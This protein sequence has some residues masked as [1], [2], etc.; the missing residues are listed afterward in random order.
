M[1]RVLACLKQFQKAERYSTM[2][3]EGF[4]RQFIQKYG[5][6]GAYS[7]DVTENRV[8]S[9]T[10]GMTPE[11]EAL[12]R[13]LSISFYTNASHKEKIGQFQN[14]LEAALEA[15][16]YQQKLIDI[17]TSRD[18]SL[19]T[20]IDLKIDIL[21][22]KLNSKKTFKEN[23]RLIEQRA[24]ENASKMRGSLSRPGSANIYSTQPLEKQTGPKIKKQ[25]TT[26]RI[27]PLSQTKTTNNQFNPKIIKT[28]KEKIVGSQPG[29]LKEIV[30]DPAT[31]K[32][33]DS[34]GMRVTSL[35]LHNEYFHGNYSNGVQMY[36]STCNNEKFYPYKALNPIPNDPSYRK[37][38]KYHRIQSGH[39]VTR[40]SKQKKSGTTNFRVEEKELEYSSDRE[41]ELVDSFDSNPEE[42]IDLYSPPNEEVSPQIP[43]RP[44][45]AAERQKEYQMEN[46][47]KPGTVNLQEENDPSADKVKPNP[48][49]SDTIK[50]PPRNKSKSN[51]NVSQKAQSVAKEEKNYF[52]EADE[53]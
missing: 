27:P 34:I 50:R 1:G 49:N 35:Y 36:M 44:K 30:K 4:L 41:R 52:D 32:N 37:S 46:G 21:R 15:K 29:K 10:R 14:A 9:D 25:N 18:K 8:S 7:H 26:A 38:A 23:N 42:I 40:E 43:Q 12:F 51:T 5:P 24:I 47:K 22:G 13:N 3:C 19:M 11:A 20:T 53:F 33:F 16:R 39:G 2:A 31:K 17:S 28:K 45:S 48:D 6:E